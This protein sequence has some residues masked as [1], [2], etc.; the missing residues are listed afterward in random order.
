MDKYFT[1]H[2]ISGDLKKIIQGQKVEL[3]EGFDSL[4]AYEDHL[5]AE[6]EKARKGVWKAKLQPEIDE[7][8]KSKIKEQYP[9][10]VNPLFNR[11]KN[12]GGFQ[13]EQLKDLDIKDALELLN[14]KFNEQIQEAKK[15]GNKGN[16]KL[17]EDLKAA[18]NEIVQLKVDIENK[19]KESEAKVQ[20]AILESQATSAQYIHD[21][22]FSKKVMAIQEDLTL[23]GAPAITLIK[24][25]LKSRGY[26]TSVAD[27]NI[28]VTGENGEDKLNLSGVKV[29]NFDELIIEI[30]K[31]DGFFKQSEGAGGEQN[32]FTKRKDINVPK[33]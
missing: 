31:A 14:S 22:L 12:F 23:K 20:K 2:N 21:D 29:A 15:S 13:D 19:E 10:I 3:P 18:Q 27:N 7:L 33:W 32:K 26:I 16:E 5:L 4:D 30:A 1:A 28:K 11:I 17:L 25:G 6:H 24:A 8:L 9:A